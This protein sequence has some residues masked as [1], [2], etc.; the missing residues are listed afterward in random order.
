MP[1]QDE[2]MTQG[3]SSG[4]RT[5]GVCSACPCFWD[6]F[7][8][9]NKKCDKINPSINQ[10]LLR[11]RK[12]ITKYATNTHEITDVYKQILLD[13]KDAKVKIEPSNDARTKIVFFEKKKRPYEFSIQDGTLTIKPRKRRWYHLL[14]MG[15]DRSKVALCVPQSTLEAISVRSNVGG[16]DICS[17]SC[18]GTFDV[19]VNTGRINLENVCCA[20]LDSKG[21]TGAVSLNNLVAKESISIERNTGS[22]LLNDCSAPEIFV[23]TKTGKVC[24]KLPPSTVFVV[25][26][27]TGKMEIPKPVIGDVIA[28]RCVIKTNTGNIRFE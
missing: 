24:G 26:T 1:C 17:V 12:M 14:R 11:G 5:M 8:L 23:K 18:S 20:K 10:N 7:L 25:R 19:R 15:I 22:V 3:K 16:V 27:N 28:G 4:N 13:A 2:A 6:F 21:N 9:F